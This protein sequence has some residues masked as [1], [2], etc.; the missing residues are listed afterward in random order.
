VHEGIVT[1]AGAPIDAESLLRVVALVRA[2]DGVVAVRNLLR[3]VP[4]AG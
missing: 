4:T 2:M 1:L 3:V